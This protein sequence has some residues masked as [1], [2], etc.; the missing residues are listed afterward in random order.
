MIYRDGPPDLR[1]SGPQDPPGQL[2]AWPLGFY[3]PIAPPVPNA[4]SSDA[5]VIKDY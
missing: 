4:P 1:G 3:G 2:R 5:A